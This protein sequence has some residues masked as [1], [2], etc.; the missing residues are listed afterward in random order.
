MEASQPCAHTV[1]MQ[2]AA[3]LVLRSNDCMLEHTGMA[4]GADLTYRVVSVVFAYHTFFSA[5]F[6]QILQHP[7]GLQEAVVSFELSR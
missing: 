3:V 5:A 6:T 2:R 4:A 7:S 1:G